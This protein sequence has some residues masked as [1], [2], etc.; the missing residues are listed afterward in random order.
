M[1]TTK[2]RTVATGIAACTQPYGHLLDTDLAQECG[3]E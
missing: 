3:E 2:E 1:V